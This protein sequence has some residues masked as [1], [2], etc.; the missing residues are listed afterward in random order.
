MRLRARRAS[1]VV[2]RA[3]RARERRARRA[4][5]HGGRARD[6]A[7]RAR[8]RG[9]PG[10]VF[11]SVRGFVYWV[12]VEKLE[13]VYLRHAVKEMKETKPGGYK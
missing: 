3:A 10:V 8:R 1:F 6:C 12:A 13:R 11:V 9:V 4:G 7:A 2:A 5:A